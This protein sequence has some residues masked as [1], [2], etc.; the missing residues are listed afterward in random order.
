MKTDLIKMINEK[1]NF[2]AGNWHKSGSGKFL[3]IKH[4]FTQEPISRL[5]LA[6]KEQVEEAITESQKGFAQMRSWTAG[7]RTELLEK[8]H[9]KLAANAEAIADIIVAEAGKPK[10]YAT[11]ELSRCL[12]T[13]KIAA[14]ESLR[15]NGE[16]VPIDFANGKG[17]I[18]ITKR[19][20]VGPVLCICPF[21]F[22]L[23]LVLHKVAPAL[24]VG[25]SV[26]IKPAPQAPMAAL[27][28]ANLIEESGYP[29]GTVSVLLCDIPEAEMM[30]KDERL[31]MV[32]FTGSDKIGWHLKTICGNK[33]ISLELGGNGAA[34][35][36]EGADLA[37]AAKVLATGS[38]LYA[39]QIC[40]STQRIFVN[41][42]DFDEF[43]ELFT[44][45]TH[46]L[47]MGDPTDK[48]VIVGPV[49][50]AAN[51]NR[52]KSWV[53]EAVASGAQ[54]IFG[55]NIIDAS[56]NIFEPTLLTGTRTT[57]K[58]LDDEIFGPVAVVEKVETFSEAIQRV[59]SSR[60]G[61][62]TGVFTNDLNEIKLAFNDLEVGGVIINNAPGFR[63]DN[64][65]Y[66]GV[67][68]SG[69]GREGLRYAMEEMTEIRLLVF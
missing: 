43:V 17:K 21:N 33:K 48:E 34:I 35:V 57:M 40:I 56:H 13:L 30:V 38:Y 28:L 53:D 27:A 7:K 14:Q 44:K 20:P 46:K 65:P 60:F 47:K 39:G 51:L 59:N 22:P 31:A 61:L 11:T 24:A 23:N 16:V 49:I 63:I 58:V 12:S 5:P 50:D 66:G 9:D 62:Q 8:L 26:I 67:K 52:I 55:G 25:C 29:K 10:S 69:F 37:N 41:S 42:V 4:K 45:E 1:G 15:L 19:V 6:S 32:S 3:E 64:M 18:A 68:H 54:L 36:S 2:I